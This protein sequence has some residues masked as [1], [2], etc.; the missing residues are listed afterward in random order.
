VYESKSMAL[1]ARKHYARHGG[2]L[3]RYLEDI[4]LLNERLTMA[5][6]VWLQ[7]DEIE[8][9]AAARTHVALNPMSN[10]KSKSGVAPMRE[11]LD[12][13]VALGLG[14]DNCSCSDA[15]NMFQSMKMFCLL[16]A[17]S[18]GSEGRPAATDAL[19]AAT[20][21]SAAALGLA[22][23]IG[24]IAPGFKADLTLLNLSDPALQPLNDPIRQL[25]YSE[26]GRGVET[27]IVDGEVLIDQGRSCRV[28]EEALVE[29][30]KRLM[31]GLRS[32]LAKVQERNRA[33][34]PYLRKAHELTLREN[35]GINRFIASP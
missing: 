31:P 32:D 13:G 19:H 24:R 29:E 14:T 35:V 15:Q 3:I 18:H 34:A 28:D 21:G 22:S 33:I 12:A 5:H 11:Y 17:A 27:V 7:S 6:G 8:R 25:V 4:G 1:N 30:V 26:S 10:L 20:Q 2:S 23:S 16:A 9:V